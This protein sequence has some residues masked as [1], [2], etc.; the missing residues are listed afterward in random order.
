[1]PAMSGSL[2]SLSP[3][4]AVT[5]TVSQSWAKGTV[6]PVIVLLESVSPDPRNT[7]VSTLD[8]VFS[9]P[10]DPATFD[11]TDVTLVRNGGANLSGALTVTALS[12]TTFRIGGPNT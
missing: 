5:N 4:N 10:V 1:M 9:Q 12:G 7:P 8:V 3:P 6:A 2:G 11:A